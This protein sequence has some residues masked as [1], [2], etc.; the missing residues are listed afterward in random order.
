M[1]N[2]VSAMIYVVKIPF[3]FSFKHAL[4]ARLCADTVLL[5]IQLDNGQYGW[6]E[7]IP[8][9]YLTGETLDSVIADLQNYYL[10]LAKSL[11]FAPGEN[12]LPKLY[13]LYLHADHERKT[14]SYGALEIAVIDALAKTTKKSIYDFLSLAKNTVK[15]TA[16]LGGGGVKSLRWVSALFR[17]LGFTDY[18]LKVGLR[19]NDDARLSTVR[20]ILPAKKFSL[21]IDA[22]AA[23]DVNTALDELQKFAEFNILSCEQPAK[24]IAELSA[25]RQQTNCPIMADESLCTMADAQ[26]LLTNNAADIWNLRLAKNGGFNG[27][28]TLS[29][30]AQANNLATHLGVLVGETSLLTAAQRALAGNGNFQHVEYGFPR[31]LLKDDPFR[32]APAGYFGVGKPLKNKVGFGIRVVPKILEKITVKRLEI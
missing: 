19:E 24:T 26:Q 30:L 28:M 13:S 16:P 25:L 6:G 14:A 31:I 8:R 7:A 12:P 20:K 17:L 22:N 9:E 27:V 2:I 10:P 3:R 11:S 5:K 29:K 15:L 1:I 4:A 18:K 21:R 23:W 32:G